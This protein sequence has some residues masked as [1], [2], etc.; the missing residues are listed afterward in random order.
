MSYPSNSHEVDPREGGAGGCRCGF[1]F[2]GGGQEAG[3][4][5]VELQA[6]GARL[7]LGVGKPLT[8]TSVGSPWW[9]DGLLPPKCVRP[10]CGHRPVW[11]SLGV[12]SWFARTVGGTCNSWLINQE[13]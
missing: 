12:A 1:G 8:A 3:R 6:P 4:S 5:C 10:A 11:A 13:A 9:S 7:V 2:I